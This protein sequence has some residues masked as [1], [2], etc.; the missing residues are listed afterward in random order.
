VVVGKRK[1][2]GR[3]LEGSQAKVYVF[4]AVENISMVK[5]EFVDMGE[6]VIVESI[7]VIKLNC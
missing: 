2:E 6:L 5:S 4:V 3:E 7:G 1:L